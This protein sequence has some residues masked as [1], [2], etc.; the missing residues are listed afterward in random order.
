MRDLLSHW[1]NLQRLVENRPSYTEQS[2]LIMA[3]VLAFFFLAGIILSILPKL[4]GNLNAGNVA[5]LFRWFGT[6]GLLITFFRYESL[7]YAGL[8]IYTLVVVIGFCL[9]LAAIVRL[10]R[11][12]K[13][14]LKEQTIRQQT[15]EKYLPRPKKK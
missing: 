6:I 12:I 7:P 8:R 2:L 15:Y 10:W 5:Q 3:I 11:A 9:W 1:F 4:R 14:T 13:P